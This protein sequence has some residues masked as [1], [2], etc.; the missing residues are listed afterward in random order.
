LPSKPLTPVTSIFMVMAGPL[1]HFRLFFVLVLASL[2]VRWF[3]ALP[4]AAPTKR[5][6]F[7]PFVRTEIPEYSFRRSLCL[8][9]TGAFESIENLAPQHFVTKIIYD[10]RSQARHRGAINYFPRVVLPTGSLTIQIG[11]GLQIEIR[12]KLNWIFGSST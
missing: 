3:E 1:R 7:P 6:I 10:A 2:V 4:L 8:V 9:A 12:Q 5:R 11:Q